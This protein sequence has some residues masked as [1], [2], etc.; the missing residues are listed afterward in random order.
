MK[1][2][3]AKGVKFKVI[4][5]W[6][7]ILLLGSFWLTVSA[8][9]DPVSMTVLPQAPREGQPVVATFKL[10]NPTSHSQATNYQFYANG[11]L[12]SAGTATMAPESSRTYKY[13]YT[14]PLQMGEQLNFVVR[15][16]S[17]QENYE[18]ILSSPSYPPQVW[19]SFASFASFSTSVM[20]SISTMT[21]YQNTFDS[22]M[23]LNVGI[24]TSL[25]LIALLI[26]LELTQPVIAG[27]TVAK[28]GR[29]KIRLSAVTWILFIIFMG[30]VYTKVVMIL[31][32]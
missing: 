25:V 2:S 27:R 13:A 19:S 11:E 16:Q 6:L 8:A 12:L 29:L 9:S 7:A 30:I 24:I 20:S 17:E 1:Q 5:V 21:Y 14:N 4:I 31:A 23:G 26:F 22:D 3:S 15:I 32:T 10:N 18:K 28:L